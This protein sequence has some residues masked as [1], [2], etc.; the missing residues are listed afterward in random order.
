MTTQKIVVQEITLASYVQLLAA[1]PDECANTVTVPPECLKFNTNQEYRFDFTG[2]T[3]WKC[4]IP[5]KCGIPRELYKTTQTEI[6]E[7]F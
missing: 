5:E 7:Q 4:I 6:P 1:Q 3:T 2:S